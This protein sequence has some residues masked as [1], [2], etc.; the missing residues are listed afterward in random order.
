M[1]AQ[2]EGEQFV[3]HPI[4]A[5]AYIRASAAMDRSGGRELRQRLLAGLSGTVVEVG[6]G[7]GRNF[8]HYPAEVTSVLAVEPE[9]RLRAAAEQAARDAPVPVRVVAGVADR[10][11]ADDASLDAAVTS[12]VLCSVPNQ[13]TALAEIHRVLRPGGSL[14]F[15]E[16]LLAEHP[17]AL[18]RAQ[19]FVDATFWPPLT[20]GCHCSRD[21]LAA[22]A[23]A[24]FTIVRPE[25]FRLPRTGLVM[26]AS[27][28]VIGTAVRT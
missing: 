25:R 13:A 15:Y 18:R 12:L 23:A 5:R 17:G 28:H 4:F 6:A 9:P 11:P 14:R 26:P 20:A 10:L 2:S 16:H 19:R 21:T 3:S 8:A 1:P 7:N 22:I 27:P 24:G